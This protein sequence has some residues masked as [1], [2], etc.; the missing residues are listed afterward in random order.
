MLFP[1][2]LLS[3]PSIIFGPPSPLFHLMSSVWIPPLLPNIDDVLYEQPLNGVEWLLLSESW[4]NARTNFI[5]NNISGYGHFWHMSLFLTVTCTRPFEL[6][7]LLCTQNLKWKWGP[8]TNKMFILQKKSFA[9][10]ERKAQGVVLNNFY[11]V[12]F[13]YDEYQPVKVFFPLLMLYT[14]LTVLF[15]SLKLLT[16]AKWIL[17]IFQAEIW[18]IH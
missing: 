11:L 5:I 4:N 17:Q 13:V 16:T 6:F 10:C 2:P 3:S 18:C 1:L 12:F 15:K 9:E 7:K 8:F 14:N